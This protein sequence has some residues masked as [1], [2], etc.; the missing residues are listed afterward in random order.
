MSKT[1]LL[2]YIGLFFV[3]L[4]LN[5]ASKGSHYPI[6]NTT[7]TWGINLSLI[8]FCIIYSI[9]QKL[10]KLKSFFF[11]NLFLFWAALGA[12]RGIVHFEN[13]WIVKNYMSGMF[14][15]S[16][17][18]FAFVFS[19]PGSTLYILRVWNKYIF[20]IFLCIF[21]WLT[22][23]GYLHFYLGPIYFLYGVFFRFITNKWKYLILYIVLFMLVADIGAR[24]QVIK[25]AICIVMAFAIYLKRFIP[26]VVVQIA[27]MSFYIIALTF[28]YLG[29][30]GRYNVFDH[31]DYEALNRPIV[32]RNGQYEEREMTDKNLADT[33]S[34]IYIEVILSALENEYVLCGRTIARGNDSEAFMDSSLTGYPERYR[35]ELCHLNIFTWLGLIGVILY[36]LIYL[37][38]SI[39]SS[40]FSN[41]IYITYLGS[42]VGFHWLYGWVEDINDFNPMNIALW[43]LIGMCLSPSFRR[44]NNSEFEIWIKSIFY[45][46]LVPPFSILQLLKRIIIKKFT[47]LYER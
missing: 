41:N 5:A 43:M 31:T 28:L 33:R 11:C 44:M 16:L 12:L 8:S 34:F 37:H 38:A 40:F 1:A 23:I 2:K 18:C 26:I 6:G 7:L 22:K 15:I 21:S 35:N 46:G 24:S 39:I 13:Y 45:N 29:L 10:F 25:A 14:S 32:F 19:Q 3:L 30:S 42:L 17:P 47:N 9:N 4:T 27:S 36:S 20:P